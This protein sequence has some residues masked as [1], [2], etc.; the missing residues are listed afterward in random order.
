[1]Y[2]EWFNCLLQPNLWQD[3]LSYTVYRSLNR[4]NHV[5]RLNFNGVLL[6]ATQKVDFTRTTTLLEFKDFEDIGLMVMFGTIDQCIGNLR[7]MIQMVPRTCLCRSGA[8]SEDV[9]FLVDNSVQ[10]DEQV[11]GKF[12]VTMFPDPNRNTDDSKRVV[13]VDEEMLLV[14]ARM[15]NFT[16]VYMNPD[17][18]LGYQQPNG[19]YSGALGDIEDERADMSKSQIVYFINTT[20]VQFLFP[21]T[22]VQFQYVVPKNYY[23]SSKRGLRLSIV[24]TEITVFHI[25]III[26]FPLGLVTLEWVRSKSSLGHPKPSWA[27]AILGTINVVTN[28]AVTIRAVS[29][30]RLYWISLILFQFIMYNVFVANMV[31]QMNLFTTTR[32]IESVQELIHETPLKLAL[33]S[34]MTD[35]VRLDEKRIKELGLTD[36]ITIG[37]TDH[38]K[39][40]QQVAQNRSMAALMANGAVSKLVPTFYDP[41]TGE[42][43]LH[44]IPEVVL[45]F[46]VAA[47]VPASSKYIEPL[48]QITMQFVEGG[49]VDHNL[50]HIAYDGYLAY[51]RRYRDGKF[52]PEVKEPTMVGWNELKFFV[53][54]GGYNRVWRLNFNGVLLIATQKVNFARTTTLLE[55]QD[56]EEIGLMIMF[57]TVDQC[58]GNLRSTIQLVTRTVALIIDGSSKRLCVVSSSRNSVLCRSGATSEDVT[59]L[60]ENSVQNDEQVNGRFRV[61]MFTDP[62]RNTYD[63]KRVVFVDDEMLLAMAKMLNFTPVY[64]NPYTVLGYQQPNGTFS[65][66]LGDIEYER[67]DMCKSQTMYFINTTNVQ[68]LFPTRRV[69]FRYVVPKNYYNTSK[70]GLRLS[71]LSSE[72]SG[73]HMSIIFWFPLGMVILEWVCSKSSS[74]QPKPSWAR[75]ILGTVN[76]VTNMAVTIRAVSSQRLYWISLILFQ[77]IMYNVFQANMVQ[78]MNLFTTARDIDSIQELIRDTSLKLALHSSMTDLVRFDEDRIKELGLTDRIIVGDTDQV[79][80]LQQVAQN[81]SM[82]ALLG[83]A[84]INKLMPTF[85]DPKTGEDLLHVIPEIVQDFHVAALVPASS[86]YIEPLNQ[87]TMQFVEGG[88]VKHN[89]DYMA[90]DG[91]LA[92]IRR[93]RDG[94]FKSEVKEPTMVGWSELRFF[95]Y[96]SSNYSIVMPTSYCT[97]TSNVIYIEL[98]KRLL[99]DLHYLNV[100]ETSDGQN[101]SVTALQCTLDGLKQPLTLYTIDKLLK[102]VYK[103]K[104]SEKSLDINPYS[105]LEGFLSRATYEVFMNKLIPVAAQLNPIAKLVLVGYRLTQEEILKLFRRAWIDYRVPN[106]FVLNRADEAS[107]ESCLLNPYR[108]EPGT[109]DER[110]LECEVIVDLEDVTDYVE[111][112]QQFLHD[113]V[114]SLNKFPLKIAIADVDLMSLAVHGPQGKIQRFTYLD[115]EIVEIMRQ[116]LNFTTEFVILPSQ[117][118]TGFVYPNGSLGGSL[119]L[120]ENSQIDLAANSRIIHS[121]NCKNLQY[122]RQLTTTKLIFIVPQNYYN[123]RSRDRVFFNTFTWSFY[124]VNIILAT[125][126]PLLLKLID[127]QNKFPGLMMHTLAVTLAVSTRLPTRIHARLIFSGI[128]LYTIITYSI[129]QA[130]IIKRLNTNNDHLDDI[131]KIDELLDSKLV[132][133]I[134]VAYATFIQPARKEVQDQ[135]IPYKKLSRKSSVAGKNVT[136]AA[137]IATMLA[138]RSTAVMIH[139]LRAGVVKARFYDDERMQSLIHVIGEHVFEFY[140]AMALPKDSPLLEPLNEI[141]VRCVE[142]GIVENEL[143][144]IQFKETLYM[145]EKNRDQHRM[146][147]DA[148]ARRFNLGVWKNVFYYYLVLNGLAL[149]V[150]ILELIVHKRMKPVKKRRENELGPLRLRS[151]RR[152]KFAVGKME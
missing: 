72:I 112:V 70:H 23:N 87:I 53:Y 82:A 35:L 32:D 104:T 47:L 60:V 93:Y 73:F 128:L 117:L 61:T 137:L 134:P 142:A 3:S 119:E 133:M 10:S 67:A 56:F 34:S 14:M 86:K 126:V 45:D 83:G 50:D 143:S 20:K 30:Q 36:R 6:L 8:T 62:N 44:V 15:L 21:T 43:L 52:Q 33:H 141:T 54:F 25:S 149:V 127:R 88:L 102:E 68:Y 16:P 129:W 101:P 74:G 37:D 27:K 80:L 48:N 75:A 39:L 145:I 100:V 28:M 57:G 131:Q 41:K 26:W 79:K 136:G 46:Y 66:A 91:Y 114:H 111:F 124:A 58:I 7:S 63:S 22:N 107:I 90:H 144:R 11:N 84:P 125:T 123:S 49:L 147:L 17:T 71:I 5:W 108:T 120:I 85:Y 69:L 31:Q 99:E 19:T 109:I 55:F 4:Y 64:M 29:S 18:V 1:M 76:V 77:F 138:S 148:G 96:V 105:H 24:S 38:A 139:D 81:R 40:L 98:I 89:L 152:V 78:Q 121:Y 140:T 110:N 12:R 146:G 116:H 113:R 118:S 122:L 94:K 2:A 106:M 95:V 103:R 51:V 13:Y 42:N 92:Y 9:T 151:K 132:P 115:G 135:D 150:F 130:I 59:F 97:L 65:G